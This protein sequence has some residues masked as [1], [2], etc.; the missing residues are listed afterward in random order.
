MT[1]LDVATDPVLVY[2]AGSRAATAWVRFAERYL[3]ATL[4]SGGWQAVRGGPGERLR[5]ITPTGRTYL[6]AGA[7]ARL[8]L[9][10]GGA[11]AYLGGALAL[12]TGTG[13]PGPAAWVRAGRR[14]G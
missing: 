14:S 13:R 7:V 1:E 12:V 2:D 5:W 8:L 9:R 6:G 4:A 3:R 10:T 11:W